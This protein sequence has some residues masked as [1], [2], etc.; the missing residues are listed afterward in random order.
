M[1]LK[2]HS[3][4]WEATTVTLSQT[5]GRHKN[6]IQS[7]LLSFSC[8]VLSD[9]WLTPWTAACQPSLSFTVSQS[10]LRFMSIESVMLS[11][12]L[13]LCCLKEIVTSYLSRLVVLV[14]RKCVL[15]KMML[16]VSR[17][18]QNNVRKIDC[19]HIMIVSITDSD[20]RSYTFLIKSLSS[21]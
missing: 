5:V 18:F 8:E 4:N 10:L 11:N 2:N 16:K 15:F 20:C 13:F 17:Y 12:H 3:A 7:C 21:T 14:E 19:F 9:S 6:D 1:L